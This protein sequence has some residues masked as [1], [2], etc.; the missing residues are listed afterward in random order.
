MDAARKKLVRAERV[1]LYQT[2][3]KFA[4]KTAN[5][6]MLDLLREKQLNSFLTSTLKGDAVKFFNLSNALV[7]ALLL[8]RM[9]NVECRMSNVARCFVEGRRTTR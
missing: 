7:R 3:F 9:S 4:S 5:Q 6:H 1:V 8:G 2:G